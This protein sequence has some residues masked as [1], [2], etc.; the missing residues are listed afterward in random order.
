MSSKETLRFDVAIIGAGV[1]GLTAALSLDADQKIGVFA[2]RPL[3][4]AASGWAQGGIAAV[5]DKD[6]DPHLHIEDTLTAGGGLCRR[7]AV[8]KIVADAP[9]AIDWLIG[10]GVDFNRDP[11]GNLALTHEGGHRRRRVV[12]VDDRSGAAIMDTLIAN[13]RLRRNIT[14]LENHV[15]VDLYARNGRCQG[16]YSLDLRT[17]Q[18]RTIA[19]AK[20]IL[21]SGGACRVYLYASTPKDTTGDGVGMAFRAGCRIRNMEFVQFHPTCLYHPAAPTLL[22]SEAIR[23]EGATLVNESG[24]RFLTDIH[25]QAELAPRDIVSQAIDKEMKRSGSDCVYLDCSSRP[26]DYWRQRFPTIIGECLRRGVWT[27]KRRLPVVP[28]AHYCCGGVRTDLRGRTDID[29][30]YA[31]GETACTGLHGANRLASNSLLE[32]LVMGKACA[33]DSPTSA[34]ADSPPVWNEQR[35]SAAKEVIMIAHNWDELRRTMWNYVGIVRND[36]RLQRARKRIRWIR[37]E[38]QEYYSRHLVNRDFLEL[39]NLAQC[40]ELIIEGAMSR[41]ESRGLHL[42]TDCP[43]KRPAAVDT[44]LSIADFKE[45]DQSLNDRCPFSGRLVTAGSTAPY[46]RHIVGFCNPQCRDD[47]AH[48]AERQFREADDRILSAKNR[49]DEKIAAMDD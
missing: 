43:E 14:F 34:V 3:G 31:I 2:K 10:Q 6:D 29:G 46:R 33:A 7:D 23:G 44:E 4:K 18:V 5:R 48:A 12:H 20:T 21:A 27:E 8:E 37:E 11:S 42:N 9:V 25:P 40:A 39:R 22:I 45:R 1:A 32:C 24:E 38:I 17:G 41:R 13:A 16:F 19:A 36:L 35:I 28:A 26:A 15:A 49:F 47:F 30:L